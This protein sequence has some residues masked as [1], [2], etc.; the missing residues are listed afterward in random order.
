MSILS[1]SGMTFC[2]WLALK[3][4]K[5]FKL[6]WLE[7]NETRVMGVLLMVLGLSFIFL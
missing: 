1:I 4:L 5:T 3:G 7:E 6:N 2:G